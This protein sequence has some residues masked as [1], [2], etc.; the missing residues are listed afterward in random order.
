MFLLVC[1]CILVRDDLNNIRSLPKI[2][3]ILDCL[4][5]SATVFGKHIARSQ[6]QRAIHSV[7][8]HGL[9]KKLQHTQQLR[10]RV[11]FQVLS[12]TKKIILDQNVHKQFY[13]RM[14]LRLDVRACTCVW[15]SMSLCLCHACVHVRACVRLCACVQGCVSV[16]ISY[17]SK[18]SKG[19]YQ[20]CLRQYRACTHTCILSRAG[21][22]ACA[23]MRAIVRTCVH[24][25]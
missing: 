21:A 24:T 3:Q 10:A 1:V 18:Q 2:G 12:I 13:G 17:H 5:R 20:H 7:L 4:R 16:R 14:L 6:L 25:S 8:I 9:T 22:F 23:C 11:V 15:V 19:D